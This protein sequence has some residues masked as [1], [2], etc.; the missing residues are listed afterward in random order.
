MAKSRYR[1]NY[2]LWVAAS[3]CLFVALGFV[4]PVAGV[5]KGDSSLWAVVNRF[6]RGAYYCSTT[7]IVVGLL[8]LA[9]S[10]AIPAAILGWV[11]QAVVVIG[12]GLRRS[13]QAGGITPNSNDV[14]A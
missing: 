4:D 12:L 2:L 6:V 10:R 13:E 14:R 9:I 5:S 1:T 7:D 8:I 11:M 3:G